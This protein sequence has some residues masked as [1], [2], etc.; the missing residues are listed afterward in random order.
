MA[1]AFTVKIG[2]AAV[3]TAMSGAMALYWMVRLETV[4]DTVLL[5]LLYLALLAL[6]LWLVGETV[7]RVLKVLIAIAVVVGVFKMWA[8]LSPSGERVVAEIEA[9]IGDSKIWGTLERFLAYMK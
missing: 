5:A 2:A 9:D 1:A 6:A 3:E 8:V 7:V 4:T